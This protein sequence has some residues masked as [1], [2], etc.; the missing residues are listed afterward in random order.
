VTIT[1]VVCVCVSRNVTL[2]GNTAEEENWYELMTEE[3]S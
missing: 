1:E 3:S 2:D